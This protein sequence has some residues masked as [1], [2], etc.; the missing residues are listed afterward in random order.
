M[1]MRNQAVCEAGM[2]SESVAV[3]YMNPSAEKVDKNFA[4]FD[5]IV[6]KVKTDYSSEGMSDLFGGP[7]LATL[8]RRRD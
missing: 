1:K 2:I 6:R 8:R 4:R 3:L 7:M 5:F